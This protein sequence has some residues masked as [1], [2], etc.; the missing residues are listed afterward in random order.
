MLKRANGI[1]VPGGFGDRGVEGKILAIRHARENKIPFLGICLGMQLAVIEFA[2]NVLGLEK[3]NSEEFEAETKTPV[4]IFMPEV[5]KTHMGATMRLGKR[6]TSL[7]VEKYPDSLSQKLYNSTK[8]DERHRHRYEVNPALVAQIEEKG[9]QFVGEDETKQRMEIIELPQ[10]QHPFFYGTQYHPEFKSRPG[11]P[12]PPFVGLVLA[13][14][15]KLQE[16]FEGKKPGLVL[17]KKLF[18]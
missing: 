1:L 13:S 3:A 15:G 2:R 10:S 5:S 4:V 17:G 8:I 14:A 11:R 7:K 16:F 18:Q 9:L 6:T 12:S